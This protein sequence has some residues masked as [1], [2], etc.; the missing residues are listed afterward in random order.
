MCRVPSSHSLPTCT[1]SSYYRRWI[2]SSLSS[3]QSHFV[4]VK[5]LRHSEDGWNG[6]RFQTTSTSLVSSGVA[7]NLIW[8]LY[9]LTSHCNFKTCV[10]G[11]HVNKTVT[12]FGGIY[13][14]IPPSLRP[15][16]LETT[17]CRFFFALVA[18]H[19][20]IH[21]VRRIKVVVIL[22]SFWLREWPYGQQQARK[23]RKLFVSDLRRKIV[24][25]NL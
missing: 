5:Q 11:P 1:C 12:D 23:N 6:A 16:W 13:T 24:I 17:S 20:F 25:W 9:V 3:L 18:I 15:C 14:D 19:T 21:E 2:R 4:V 22:S 8:G 7:R 10:N